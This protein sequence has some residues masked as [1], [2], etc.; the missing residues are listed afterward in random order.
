[1]RIIAFLSVLLVLVPG[2]A[3]AN[4]GAAA[5]CLWY[6]QPAIVP[7]APLPWV[8]EGAH[9]SEVGNLPGKGTP[10]SWE[11]QSLPIG[12]GRIGGTV[13]GGDRLD[14]VNLNEASLWTGG[15]NAGRNGEGYQYGPLSGRNEFG[16]YQPFGNLYI[17]YPYKGKAGNYRR[18]LD[19]RTAVSGTAFSAGGVEYSRQCFASHPDNVLVYAASASEPGALDALI[20]LTPFHHVHYRVEGD[21][22]IMGGALA[23]GE[24]FEGRARIRVT[25]GSCSLVGGAT[26]VDVSYEGSK[27][28]MKPRMSLKGIPYFHVQGADSFEVYIALSTD[29]KM[30][31]KELW[32]GED[33]A[34][35][36]E[37][38]LAAVASKGFADVLQTHVKDYQSLYN[39]LALC[40]GTPAGKAA[41]LPTDE[42]LAAYRRNG[43]NDPGL[44]SMLYQYGRY[45]LISSSREGGLPANLQGIW[46]DKVHAEWASDYHNNINLQMCYWGAEVSNLSPCHL[47]LVSFIRAMEEPLREMTK[48]EFGS[49]IRG[50]TARIS[51]NPWGGGGWKKWNPPVNAWYAL[52]VWEHYLFTQD[53]GYLESMAYPLMK[54]A[55]HFWEDRLKP[56][57]EGGRGLVSDGKEVDVAAYPELASIR[58]GSLVA[59]AGWSHE[60]GPVE[61]GVAHDQQLIWEL[62]DNTAQA[63]DILGKD[64]DWAAS[65]RAKRDSLVANRVSPGGYLQEWII[66]RPGMV[67]GHRHTSHLVGVYPGASISRGKTPLLAEAAMKSL[68]LRG[69][70]GDNCRSWTWPWRTAL[71]AR[72]GRADRAY[73]MVQHY[74]RF[75]VLDN[76]FANHPPMQMDGTLGMT[77][78]MSEMLIQSHAGQIELLPALPDA[79]KNGFVRGIR[80]RGDITVNMRWEEGKVTSYSLSTASPRPRPVKVI[81]NGRQV[82]VTPRVIGKEKAYEQ[83]EEIGECQ[84]P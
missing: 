53:K 40:L 18:W 67:A 69:L 45:V 10:D 51:Q 81:V 29:Y 12:N 15:E 64:A 43:G 47:P 31:C 65:L 16:S 60:W 32:K 2:G 49:H 72:F 59:P 80:A 13:F 24:K 58:Q 42:R 56:L 38:T 14:R 48:K 21:T 66:D 76:L 50:W 71:W 4:G 36:N 74:L 23:N 62:F 5:D 54:E 7:P 77:G 78:G 37:R 39:R 17:A 84:A 70:S 20:A 26:Q 22:I 25:G 11:S 68:E 63:A 9:P 1:M 83:K 28:S 6:R 79:W 55:C 75:N 44:E 52:H 82:M 57:G 61:D 30:D 35:Q 73:D 27:A 34:V 46:N 41:Q 33:P 19:L 8:E 3:F